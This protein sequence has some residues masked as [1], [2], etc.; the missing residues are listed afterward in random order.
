MGNV[1]FNKHVRR[2]PAKA[3]WVLI[4]P[5]GDDQIDFFLTQ[6]LNDGSERVGVRWNRV[7]K[8]A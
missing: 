6:T 5:H 2:L 1:A 7:P 4:T 3:R 8:L